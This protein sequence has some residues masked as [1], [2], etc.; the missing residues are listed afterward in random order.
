YDRGIRENVLPTGES[1]EREAAHQE[2]A[3]ERVGN[4]PRAH[5]AKRGDK[6]SGKYENEPDRHRGSDH[7]AETVEYS[8]RVD[9]PIEAISAMQT[10]AINV[11][12]I[13]YSTIVAPD[14]S[15][16]SRAW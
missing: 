15:A 7:V 1:I 6:G 5:I 8:L 10:A 2:R 11:S 14:S 9:P 13:A 3:Y 4:A 12:M 16:N